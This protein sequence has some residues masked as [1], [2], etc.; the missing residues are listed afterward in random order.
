MNKGIGTL[1]TLA[2]L[3]A[4]KRWE[5]SKA[6]SP[7]LTYDFRNLPE[8]EFDKRMMKR[9]KKKFPR[10]RVIPKYAPG[11]EIHVFYLPSLFD[12]GESYSFNIPVNLY[13][14]E[15]FQQYGLGDVDIAD[16]TVSPLYGTE[17][18]DA[19]MYQHIKELAKNPNNKILILGQTPNTEQLTPYMMLHDLG[20]VTRIDN[21]YRFLFTDLPGFLVDTSKKYRTQRPYGPKKIDLNLRLALVN[22]QTIRNQIKRGT[23]SLDFYGA[24]DIESDAFAS[25]LATGKVEWLTPNNSPELKRLIRNQ[26]P[27]YQFLDS[28]QPLINMRMKRVQGMFKV[29]DENQIFVL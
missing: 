21:E 3:I 25:I 24:N 12:Y 22:N 28:Y 13:T 19:I 27:T 29:F 17:K 9:Y 15:D 14:H 6:G 2:A 4:A 5:Q 20:E 11:Y 26:Y 8:S 16:H 10:Y 1:G 23:L 7:T 18:E